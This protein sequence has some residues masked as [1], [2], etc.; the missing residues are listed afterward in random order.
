MAKSWQL[1]KE[2]TRKLP[3]KLLA[4]IDRADVSDVSKNF[5]WVFGQKTL[6]SKREQSKQLGPLGEK[7]LWWL[8]RQAWK[9]NHAWRLIWMRSSLAVGQETSGI[10]FM[11]SDWSVICTSNKPATT[12]ARTMK[13]SNGA[14]C[15][16]D[17]FLKEDPQYHRCT[18]R[19]RCWQCWPFGRMPRMPR[20]SDWHF[21]L[22]TFESFEQR[23]LQLVKRPSSSASFFCI[24]VN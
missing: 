19:I 11:A 13:T 4:D 7:P 14:G 12:T 21:P 3:G 6:C 15:K 17:A 22:N 1:W 8:L 2:L 10:T 24:S 23:T 5:V 18:E 9:D 16:S 20:T